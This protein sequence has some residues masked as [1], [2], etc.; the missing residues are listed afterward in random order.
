MK[1]E[2][3][4]ISFENTNDELG[5]LVSKGQSQGKFT[6][7][8]TNKDVQFSEQLVQDIKT[9]SAR[10]VKA[11]DTLF[12]SLFKITEENAQEFGTPFTF[13]ERFSLANL[14]NAKD[15]SLIYNLYRNIQEKRRGFN[16]IQDF[17]E[18]VQSRYGENTQKIKAGFNPIQGYAPLMDADLK[19]RYEEKLA[20]QGDPKNRI[21]RE[22]IQK[23]ESLQFAGWE[24]VFKEEQNLNLEMWKK[25]K[26]IAEEREIARRVASK[27]SGWQKV[28]DFAQGMALDLVFNAPVYFATGLAGYFTKGSVA[29]AF[30]IYG[31]ENVMQGEI[32]DLVSQDRFK[33]EGQ[34]APERGLFERAIEFGLGG[35]I[36]AI[37]RAIGIRREAKNIDP[38]IKPP[39]ETQVSDG[40][41]EGINAH[42][43]FASEMGFVEGDIEIALKSNEYSKKGEITA[44][45]NSF[46]VA[47]E[48][49]DVDFKT[50][51]LRDI[52]PSNAGKA[53]T[54]RNILDDF[55]PERLILEDGFNQG[56]IVIDQNY[57][58]V[59]GHSRFEAL[60]ILH[61][62]DQGKVNLY[63]QKLQEYFPHQDLSF[64]SPILVKQLTGEHSQSTINKLLKRGAEKP[65]P[66]FKD[67]E[68]GKAISEIETIERQ[69]QEKIDDVLIGAP[70]QF[71]LNDKLDFEAKIERYDPEIKQQMQETFS[72]I[73][74]L[75]DFKTCLIS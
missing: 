65:N 54:I 3:S 47:D 52:N 34:L 2:I 46:E 30:M 19:Q 66:T 32:I 57:N 61:N 22:Q 7:L 58:I 48:F 72:F 49:V 64:E 75:K 42:N 20:K 6:G 26:V 56:A 35:G 4:S 17:I 16:F 55:D 28:G 5:A 63:R 33:Y 43:A 45:K 15:Q 1:P 24:N 8:G 44:L 40:I 53:E 36:G 38:K 73:Q 51:D 12:N 11:E 70:E 13:A 67:S 39:T 23:D 74:A 59:S 9:Q 50:V 41:T 31:I 60:N 37:G 29:K 69:Y 27:T 10:T 68:I 71:N 18:D 62:A 25:R 14:R 21:T